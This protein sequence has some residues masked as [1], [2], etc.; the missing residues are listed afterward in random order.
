MRNTHFQFKQFALLQDKAA[1]KLGADS[2]LLGCF[3]NVEGAERI[4]DIGTGTGILAL[5]MA[6]KSNAQIDAVEIDQEA[7]KQAEQNANESIW[8]DRIRIHH[9][10]I[11][12][13]SSTNKYDLIISNPPYYRNA[14]NMGI[15]N[16][17]RALARHDKDLS[18]EDLCK[19]A[20]RL[21]KNEGMFWLILPHQE[22]LEFIQIAKQ[23]NLQLLHLINIKPKPEKE[24]NRLILAFGKSNKTYLESTFTIYQSN[25]IAT[26]E[27]V[28]L[29]KDFYLWKDKT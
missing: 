15:E 14:K 4:L 11:Q 21:M 13:F 12:N 8:N 22:G 10:A 3:T 6:Q 18:F 9:S 5:M 23:H 28:E 26:D 24:L 19:E 7:F 1:M 17:K 29:T 16:E 20:Y 2:V 25:G 27:Y